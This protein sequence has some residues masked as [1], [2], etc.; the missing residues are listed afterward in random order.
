MYCFEVV[1]G[2]EFDAVT[3]LRTRCCREPGFCD[4]AGRGFSVSIGV[5]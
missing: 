3:S 1:F 2:A 4:L 5:V